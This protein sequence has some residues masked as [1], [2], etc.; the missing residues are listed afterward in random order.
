MPGSLESGSCQGVAL[1]WGSGRPWTRARVSTERWSG[2]S[3]SEK[4]EW[5]WRS[6]AAAPYLI[7]CQFSDAGYY[8]VPLLEHHETLEDLIFFI[9]GGTNRWHV[10]LPMIYCFAAY[11]LIV[12]NKKLPH[13]LRYHLITAMLLET[14]LQV[15]WV[16][17]NWAPLI[18]FNGSLGI[19]YWAAVGFLYIGVLLYAAQC[20]LRGHYSH[21]PFVTEAALIHTE[22]RVGGFLR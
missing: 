15:V 7:A 6:L 1:R 5:W 8:V 19:Y 21:I 9:P 11:S 16:A 13:F 17:S 2:K 3:T 12:K 18:H 20:A 4:P 22:Y 10:W 14:A